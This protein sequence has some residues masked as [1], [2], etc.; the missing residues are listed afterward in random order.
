MN[1]REHNS[2]SHY[3][4]FLPGETDE[5]NL[6][7]LLDIQQISDS[8]YWVMDLDTDT[9][10][11]SPGILKLL[12]ISQSRRDISLYDLLTYVHPED[13]RHIQNAISDHLQGSD[14]HH[15]TYRI[16]RP[17]GNERYIKTVT[18]LVRD[19]E[20]ESVR[21]LG[22]GRDITAESA[23]EEQLRLITTMDEIGRIAVSVAHDFGNLT[24]VTL[25]YSELLLADTSTDSPHVKHLVQITRAAR[26]AASLSERVLSLGKRQQHQIITVSIRTLLQQI[27]G[28]IEKI[29]GDHIDLKCEISESPCMVLGDPGL[30]EQMII[31]LVTN[32]RDAMPDG[33]ELIIQVRSVT[34]DTEST[35]IVSDA[36]PGDYVVISVSDTGIGMD[37]TTGSHV[38][39]PFYTTKG[40]RGTGL[41]LTAVHRTVT[42][43][44]GY[45][46]FHS[47]ENTGTTFTILLPAIP[48]SQIQNQELYCAGSLDD[49]HVQVLM[50]LD[51]RDLLDACTA[52]FGGA[53]YSVASVSSPD[54]LLNTISRQKLERRV[55]LVE[56]TA[57]TTSP[58][59]F[60][61][62]IE[63][64]A[65]G[66]EMLVIA[67][68]DDPCDDVHDSRHIS[69]IQKPFFFRELRHRITDTLFRNERFA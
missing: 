58:R 6:R 30:L 66:V 48:P 41:G 38:F 45:I 28:F 54:E 21:I 13:R 44:D 19:P 27:Q 5:E 2:L 50:L 35:K 40:S 62:S 4:E 18:R 1:T 57:L 64:V 39:E 47:E 32:A 3:R 69:V 37:E 7:L 14:S 26:Q 12:G 10:S 15:A 68:P 31:N 56:N 51:D 42:Q 60:Y 8:V 59:D 46:S 33:G 63:N 9:I 61:E 65:T 36:L 25:G 11:C 34:I 43:H 55:V 24:S 53:K 29:G 17:D 16:L 67:E 22:A 23:M 49:S 20:S 52:L